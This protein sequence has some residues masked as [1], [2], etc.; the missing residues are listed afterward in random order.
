MCQLLF[1]FCT[2]ILLH[3][4][5]N[6]SVARTNLSKLSFRQSSMEEK[7]VVYYSQ[8]TRLQSVYKWKARNSA[9]SLCDTCKCVFRML[10]TCW[11]SNIFP[12]DRRIP[13]HPISCSVKISF[14]FHLQLK[15]RSVGWCLFGVLD[16]VENKFSIVKMR[17]SGSFGRSS[18]TLSIRSNEV[19]DTQ[20]I[21]SKTPSLAN[22]NFQALFSARNKTRLA[23]MFRHSTYALLPHA[24]TT[25]LA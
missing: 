16:Y 1:Y 19:N 21:V 3:V 23:Q 2:L 17:L 5:V 12:L 15:V 24:K 10:L 13:V 14:W 4:Q 22:C 8:F 20:I 18:Y 25:M 11:L 6:D 9:I 7:V